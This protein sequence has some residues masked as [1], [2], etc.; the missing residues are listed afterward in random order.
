MFL[1]FYKYSLTQACKWIPGYCLWKCFVFSANIL[2]VRP[3]NE[4]WDI[5]SGNVS[6]FLQIFS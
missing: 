2:L 4:Y 1:L 6:S 5:V 3:A